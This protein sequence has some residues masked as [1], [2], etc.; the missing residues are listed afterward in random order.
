MSD[1]QSRAEAGLPSVTAP[2]GAKGKIFGK[3]FSEYFGFQKVILGLVAIVGIARLVMSLAGL[4]DSTV[5]WFPMTVVGLVGMFY[6]G[7]AVHMRGFGSYKQLLALV[8][9]QSVLQNSIAIVGIAFT[10][11]GMPNIFGAPEY[12]GPFVK[13]QWAH[14][15]GHVIG[16]M[17]IGSLIG[18]G[19]A[20]LV[21]LVTK[22]VSPR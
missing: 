20:S 11:A 6:Y 7:V 2:I 17:G 14:I 4:P 18:W 9:F 16:G 15:L 21:L 5:R 13:I 8:F 22:K 12:S 10:M 3:S 1:A 19:I